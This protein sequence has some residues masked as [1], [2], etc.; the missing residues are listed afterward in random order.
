AQH[1]IDEALVGRGKNH[2]RRLGGNHRLELQQID[3]AR[4]DELGLRQRSRDT[5][6]RLVGK[7]HGSFRHGVNIAGEAHVGEIIEEILTEAASVPEPIEFLG[8]NA[9]FSE[10]REHLLESGRNQ[11]AAVA[12]K[13]AH[14]E[15]EHRGFGLTTIQI[16][17]HHVE[18]VEIGQQHACRRI[19][20]ATFPQNACNGLSTALTSTTVI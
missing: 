14:K 12:R 17:L 6:N 4:L 9:Q 16:C 7:E 18:L 19:H 2:A 20:A 8:G 10:K 11:K 1:E 15:L 13:L 5:Q 3:H